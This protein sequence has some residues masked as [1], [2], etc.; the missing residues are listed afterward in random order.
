MS[1][2]IVT[3]FYAGMFFS[4]ALFRS[5][6]GSYLLMNEDGSISARDNETSNHFSFMPT[7][8][9]M[10]MPIKKIGMDKNGIIR[11]IS[12]MGIRYPLILEYNRIDFRARDIYTVLLDDY[13]FGVFDKRFHRLIYQARF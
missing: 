1:H 2:I 9:D 7:F 13:S 6:K 3:K 5:N 8:L 4:N 11:A 10:Q 12:V